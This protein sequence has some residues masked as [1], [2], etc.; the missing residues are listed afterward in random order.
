MS[1]TVHHV[2]YSAAT[3]R[4]PEGRPPAG[5][6]TSWWRVITARDLRYPAAAADAAGTAGS[7]RIPAE[8][9]RHVVVR[10]LVHADTHDSTAT[11]RR[12]HER[13]ARAAERA[14]LHRALDAA[15]A[16]P[17]DDSDDTVVPPTRHRHRV[18]W[19]A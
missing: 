6:V 13:R 16:A 7:R 9:R 4:L 10:E 8:V 5:P 17:Y 11:D 2:T 15:A 3:K 12:I 1:R 18:R 19:E 14:A